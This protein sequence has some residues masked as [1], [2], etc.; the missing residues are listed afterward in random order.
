MKISVIGCGYLGAVHAACMASLGHDV[1]GIDVD[2]A[3]IDSLSRGEAPFFEP[4]L[5]EMLR[6]SLATGRLSFGTPHSQ[7]LLA[8]VDVHFSDIAMLTE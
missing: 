2:T 7:E 4:G 1:V 3:K 5:E 6:A 8:D